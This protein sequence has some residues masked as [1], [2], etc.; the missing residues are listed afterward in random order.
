MDRYHEKLD[1][2]INMLFFLLIF[3]I[4]CAAYIGFFAFQAWSEA[5]RAAEYSE[6][7]CQQVGGSN[8]DWELVSNRKNP[9]GKR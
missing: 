7:I 4:L 5:E 6:A 3:A 8:C 9:T 2:I 1:S